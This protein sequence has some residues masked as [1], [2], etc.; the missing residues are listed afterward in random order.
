[1]ENVENLAQLESAV[2]KLLTAINEMKQE[3][4]VLRAR[5]DSRDQEIVSLKQQL[6]V[7]QDERSQVEQRV[8]G[9]LSSIDKWE[10]LIESSD[11]AEESE[12]E[13]EGKTL[14]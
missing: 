12:T 4:L 5:L 2:D 8:S 14:F 10:K 13:A 9:L 3:K 11:V 6:Q 7:L 1:M